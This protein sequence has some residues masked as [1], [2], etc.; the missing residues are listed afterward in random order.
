MCAHRG[1][2]ILRLETLRLETALWRL[3]LCVL[4]LLW[5]HLKFTGLKS[6]LIC[7]VNKFV[8]IG[9]VVLAFAKS[10]FTECSRKHLHKHMQISSQLKERVKRR[11]Q[12]PQG[13]PSMSR[14]S[15]VSL[16]LCGC[17]LFQGVWGSHG[18]CLWNVLFSLTNWN[19]PYWAAIAHRL[20]GSSGRDRGASGGLTSCY[21][22]WSALLSHT[23]TL[24]VCIF[25]S[26]RLGA[27]E[28]IL[29]MLGFSVWSYGE[30]YCDSFKLQL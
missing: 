11:W 16:I 24:S 27:R 1:R 25:T 26:S 13:Q 6:N 3:Q 17:V 28:F 12:I 18:Q 22:G 7:K 8:W 5:T 29:K 4:K 9:H 2:R 19:R 15:T 30:E 21:E 10:L 14:H 23:F 20:C